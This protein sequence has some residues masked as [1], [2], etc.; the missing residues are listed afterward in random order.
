MWSLG[1]YFPWE[2]AATEKPYAPAPYESADVTAIQLL[3]RGECPAELQ[4]RA[5]AW[6]VNVVCATYDQSYR[7]A[8][9]RDTDFAEGKR[10]VG[11]TIVKMLKLSAAKVRSESNEPSETI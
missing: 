6:I 5:L 4:K 2:R 9:T 7:P 8:S 1:N 10:W 3:E 11:N